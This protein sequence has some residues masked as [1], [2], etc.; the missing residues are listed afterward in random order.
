MGHKNPETLS[1]SRSTHIH[2]HTHTH[3]HTQI[4]GG[5]ARSVVDCWIH[6]QKVVGSIHRVAEEYSPWSV[7]LTLI[8]AF[9]PSPC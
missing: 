1:L 4:D 7:V 6:D 3:T 2:T 8:S 9:I 5:R